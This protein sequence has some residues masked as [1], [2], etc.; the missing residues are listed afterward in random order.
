MI[1]KNKNFS[2]LYYWL[3]EVSGVVVMTMKPEP[4]K[5]AGFM[6]SVL[7]YLKLSKWVLI[8]EVTP[9]EDNHDLARE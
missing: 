5:I 9:I 2:N 3:D 7:Y 6:A 1:E 8:E 4:P